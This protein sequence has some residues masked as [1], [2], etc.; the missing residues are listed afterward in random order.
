MAGEIVQLGAAVKGWKV[1]DRVCANYTPDLVHGLL[2]EKTGHSTLGGQ[3]H[4]VLTEYRTFPAH[5]L[6]A[7]PEHLSVAAM[8]AYAALYGPVPVKAGDDVLV[9]GTSGVSIFALQFARAAGA[10]VIITS[11]SDE[12]LKIASRLGA[13]HVINYM[14]SPDWDEEVL[15]LVSLLSTLSVTGNKIL[16]SKTNGEGVDHVMEVPR[17][18]L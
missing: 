10:N 6:V 5:S 12:K 18:T 13:K 8:T 14:T 4:G 15:K 7:I 9:L 1:G 2:N 3:S 11:S 17:N 16:I